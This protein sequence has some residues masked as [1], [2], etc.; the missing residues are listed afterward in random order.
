MH[1]KAVIHLPSETEAEEV[2]RELLE[3]GLVAGTFVNPGVSQYHW[4]DEIEEE[5]YWRLEAFCTEEQE[6]A[7]IELVE[8]QS[9]EETPAIAFTSIDGNQDFLDWIEEN[10]R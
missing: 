3:E 9:S 8:S 2:G 6:D 4:K 7:I 5:Q 1:K 10:T